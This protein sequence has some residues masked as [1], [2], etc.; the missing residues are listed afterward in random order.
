MHLSK[1]SPARREV[2]IRLL[3]PSTREYSKLPLRGRIWRIAQQPDEI[4]VGIKIVALAWALLMITMPLNFESLES[5]SLGLHYCILRV[6]SNRV[7]WWDEFPCWILNCELIW[8]GA[9]LL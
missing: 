9:C 8:D 5:K 4:G 3:K 2:S 1:C 6:E 7:V